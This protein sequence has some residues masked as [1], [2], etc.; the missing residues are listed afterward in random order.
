MRYLEAAVTLALSFLDTISQERVLQ[1]FN[2]VEIVVKHEKIIGSQSWNIMYCKDTV[3]LA[4]SDISMW[5]LLIKHL[6]SAVK[7][8][9]CAWRLRDCI[10]RASVAQRSCAPICHPNRPPSSVFQVVIDL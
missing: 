8:S 10:A 7:C 2:I 6:S 1:C 5:F 9:A 4:S 3:L